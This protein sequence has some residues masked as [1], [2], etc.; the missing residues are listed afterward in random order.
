MTRKSQSFPLRALIVEQSSYFSK[1][2]KGWMIDL[3]FGVRVCAD[4]DEAFAMLTSTEFD[5]IVCDLKSSPID[6][7]G[8]VHVLRRM[9]GNSNRLKPV[10]LTCHFAT[11]TRVETARDVGGSE[12]IAKPLSRKVFTQ[13]IMAALLH[14]RNFIKAGKFFGPDRRRQSGNY[15]GVERRKIVPTKTPVTED[16]VLV[17][18]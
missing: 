13:R 4:T 1:L 14:K 16:C 15:T 17:E 7:F 12:F 18:V 10:V 9:R 8:F 2:M 3:G 11:R 6:G 5:L